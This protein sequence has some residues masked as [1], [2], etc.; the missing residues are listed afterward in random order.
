MKA[1]LNK[2]PNEQPVQEFIV[3]NECAQVFSGLKSGYPAF[4]DD[5]D[6]AKPLNNMNQVR[7]IQHGTLH[8]LE[9][10]YI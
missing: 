6:S 4:S 2:D 3:I 5:W 1:V 10:H 8:T 9:I 7:N